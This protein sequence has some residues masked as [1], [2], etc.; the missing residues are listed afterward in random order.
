MHFGSNIVSAECPFLHV[1][2]PFVFLAICPFGKMCFGHISI[3]S[4]VYRPCFHSSKYLSA[5]CPFGHTSFGHMSVRLFVFRSFILPP[6]SK[7]N[8]TQHSKGWLFQKPV[9]TTPLRRYLT[10]RIVC[11]GTHLF[12]RHPII[13]QNK[14]KQTSFI[15]IHISYRLQIIFV[16]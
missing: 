5:I 7:S 8:Q 6:M 14:K 3:L 16:T 4:F 12:T 10:Q 11:S 9:T 13:K 2:R 15:S 1:F